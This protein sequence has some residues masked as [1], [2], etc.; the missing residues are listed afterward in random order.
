VF[1]LGGVYCLASTVD[2]NLCIALLLR[3]SLN[4]VANL[5]VALAIR[6]CSYFE[7]MLPEINQKFG[8]INELEVNADGCVEA[9]V[10]PGHGR[11]IDRERIQTLR[12]AI[13]A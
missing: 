9:P 3:S 11:E 5:H 13:L 4:N 10:E 12:T 2:A 1:V 7:V 8:L 6:N